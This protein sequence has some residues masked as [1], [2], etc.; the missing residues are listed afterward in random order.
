MIT[1]GVATGRRCCDLRAKISA[2]LK[3]GLGRPMVRELWQQGASRVTVV[4]KNP[5]IFKSSPPNASTMCEHSEAFL[6]RSCRAA[7]R[8]S[9]WMKLW[10]SG[11]TRTHPTTSVNKRERR[12][13]GA[14]P[15]L[16]RAESRLSK[17]STRGFVGLTG[18]RHEH[19][20]SFAFPAIT[21]REKLTRSLQHQLNDS[22]TTDSIQPRTTIPPTPAFVFF[23]GVPRDV[24]GQGRRRLKA[25]GR[26]AGRHH[27]E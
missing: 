12:S 18:F 3:N 6:T 19:D 11:S 1:Q 14:L 15:M 23:A 26:P 21:P 17:N 7:R 13:V 16:S 10:D 5:G 22:H 2:L 8:A 20:V 9:R 27:P 24:A 4:G 25:P